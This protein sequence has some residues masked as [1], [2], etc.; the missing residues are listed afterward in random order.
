MVIETPDKRHKDSTWTRDP[1][2]WLY[3]G[4]SAVAA[5]APELFSRD[6]NPFG[7]LIAFL[8]MALIFLFGGVSLIFALVS[9]SSRLA[10]SAIAGMAV[11][12]CGFWATPVINRALDQ[13]AFWN[14]FW[15]K[16]ATFNKMVADQRAKIPAGQPV[17]MVVEFDDRSLFVTATLFE[18]V[19]YDETDQ[20]ERYPASVI[21]YWPYQ[22]SNTGVVSVDGDKTVEHI[23]GHY[24]HIFA[25]W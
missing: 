12:A 18:Y 22:G 21:G 3:V 16:E 20:A 2:P 13:V 5:I 10:L 19:I 11:I 17:R 9:R 25:S 15:N 14:N 8:L 24:Y 7:L 4:V 1:W 6:Q 23:S